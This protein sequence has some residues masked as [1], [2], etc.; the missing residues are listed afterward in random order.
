MK[1]EIRYMKKTKENGKTQQ[2]GSRTAANSALKYK[3]RKKWSQDDMTAA[4]L[5]VRDTK[6][7]YLKAAQTY[8][9]PRTPLFR[10]A[11]EKKTLVE[12]TLNKN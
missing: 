4:I 8:I 12:D 11:E 2:K 7:G 5:A 10:L 9:V 3:K 1:L 6:M